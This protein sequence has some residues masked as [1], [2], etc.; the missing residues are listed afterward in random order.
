MTDTTL[1]AV[2]S[3]ND[4]MAQR[5]AKLETL[6][7]DGNAFPNDFRRNAV[8]KELHAMYGDE[9]NETL[10]EKRARVSVA[11]RMMLCRVMGK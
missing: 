4:L 9:D 1:D 10:Q 3:E 6:R 5:R 2:V 8:A 7:S 11:G